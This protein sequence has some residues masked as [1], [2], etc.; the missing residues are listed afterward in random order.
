MD[1]V[2]RVA[3]LTLMRH[4]NASL[5]LVPPL[6]NDK[7]F[8]HSFTADLDDPEGLQGFWES[9][10]TTPAALR[11]QITGAVL[12][13]LRN[14][15]LRD[16]VRRTFGPPKSSFDMAKVL[17]GGIL[18]ARLPKGQIG[19]ETSQLMGS[20][21]LASVWQA[22]T[23]RARLPEAERRDAAVYVD[24][25]HNFLN[26]PGSVADMLAEARGYRLS[27]VLAHQHLAQMPP[28]AADAL[29]ANARTKIWFTCSPKDA[30]TLAGHTMPYLSGHDLSQL[31]KHTAAV[32]LVVDGNN[33][34][35]FT[36]HTAP[37][38]PAR[39]SSLLLPTTPEPGIPA[40]ARLA[41]IRRP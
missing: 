13:R 40:I 16:F 27:L 32:R 23:A 2:M 38:R 36:V 21:V 11:I 3:C 19:E 24:E 17:D 22:A 34:A 29:A 8:R 4:A 1:D 41:R 12:A 33:T 20:F 9:Y 37:P 10:E 28:D 25:A 39:N 5:T 31:G 6:L 30:E 18:L 26:L 35:P 15:M 7:R 14:L